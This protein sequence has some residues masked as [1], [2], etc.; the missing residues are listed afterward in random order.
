MKNEEFHVG[1]AGIDERQRRR[2]VME[3]KIE[4]VLIYRLSASLCLCGS[5]SASTNGQDSW[6]IEKAIEKGSD[7]FFGR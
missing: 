3:Y 1:L 4:F 6:A 2:G 7:P 5:S